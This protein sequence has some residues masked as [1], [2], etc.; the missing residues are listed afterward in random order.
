MAGSSHQREHRCCQTKDST[1]QLE[2]IRLQLY[3]FKKKHT[4]HLQTHISCNEVIQTSNQLQCF[5]SLPANVFYVLLC[6][7]GDG[8]GGGCGCMLCLQ[9]S[10]CK[11]QSFARTCNLRVSYALRAADPSLLMEEDKFQPVK[12]RTDKGGTIYGRRR[13]G[14]P[15]CGPWSEPGRG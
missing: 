7:L 1:W 6:L 3:R 15:G 5:P 12:E 8:G 2:S 10:Q 14:T 11:V 13:S 9:H 4:T